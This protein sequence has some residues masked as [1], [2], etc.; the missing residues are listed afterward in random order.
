MASKSISN[1]PD[2]G[3]SK[4][5]VAGSGTFLIGLAQFMP[6]DSIYK[7]ILIFLSPWIT[8]YFATVRDYAIEKYNE[9]MYRKSTNEAKLNI[10]SKIND[11]NILPHQK[12]EYLKDLHELNR[13]EVDYDLS[14]VK[15]I[16]NSNKDRASYNKKRQ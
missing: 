10:V 8:I 2:D 9:K 15:S 6:E 16:L 1:V 5:V 7:K 3:T 14:K 12:E 4:L 13:M 11:G